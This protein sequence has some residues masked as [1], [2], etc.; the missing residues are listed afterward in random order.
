MSHSGLNELIRAEKLI[1]EGKID[2]ALKL[3]N[4]F[5][6]KKDLLQYEWISYYTAKSRIATYFWD[7]Y[8][9]N[10][11]AEEAYRESQ[12]LE[13]SLLLLDVYMQMA[14]S[15]NFFH[16]TKEASK[17]IKMSEDLLQTL[18][19]DL[20]TELRKRNA[21]IL[22][23]KAYNY[24]WKGKFEKAI[25]YAKQ[26][27]ELRQELEINA[28][29]ALSFYQLGQISWIRGDLNHALEY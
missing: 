24:N 2:K 1:E 16:K 3:I 26:A 23:I 15:S 17:F 7:R 29:I 21:Y 13:N 5:G 9:C 11:Y 18:P 28:D 19:Q 8:E 20:S 22:W 27:L 12:K 10:K 14:T 6:E 25:K 4:E